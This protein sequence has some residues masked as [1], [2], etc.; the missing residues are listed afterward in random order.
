MIGATGTREG[1]IMVRA[2][3][4]K[5]ERRPPGRVSSSAASA[6]GERDVRVD[7]ERASP[8][9]E[10]MGLTAVNCD[11]V[12][13]RERGVGSACAAAAAAFKSATWLASSCA[14]RQKNTASAMTTMATRPPMTPPTM[15]PMGVVA[16]AG[17]GAGLKSN[18]HDGRPAA[19]PHATPLTEP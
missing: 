13:R 17:D 10:G 3:R 11:A 8:C 18:A 2:E 9:T 5:G 14:R 1:V 12:R 15:A 6:P 7:S 19:E 16:G 4:D